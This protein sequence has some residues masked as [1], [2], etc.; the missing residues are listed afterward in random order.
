[1]ITD[2]ASGGMTGSR[3]GCLRVARY[4]KHPATS[5]NSG[6]RDKRPSLLEVWPNSN[7]ARLQHPTQPRQVARTYR[8]RTTAALSMVGS[9]DFLPVDVGVTTRYVYPHRISKEQY[10]PV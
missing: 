5:P 10:K 3:I 2:W 4:R 1:M 6:K 8:T 9:L 7:V